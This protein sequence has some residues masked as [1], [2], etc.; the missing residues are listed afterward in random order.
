MMSFSRFSLSIPTLPYTHP[1]SSALGS[2]EADR[3]GWKAAHQE[4]FLAKEK[5]NFFSLGTKVHE[6]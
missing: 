3:L 5:E 1:V 6:E 4:C 2:E